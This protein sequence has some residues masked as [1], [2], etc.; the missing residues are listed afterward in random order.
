MANLWVCVRT[1]RLFKHTVW[2]NGCGVSAEVALLCP[3]KSW[4]LSLTPHTH[5]HTSGSTHSHT[6]TSITCLTHTNLHPKSPPISHTQTYRHISPHTAATPHTHRATRI[7][8]QY[9]VF[10]NPADKTPSLSIALRNRSYTTYGLISPTRPPLPQARALW[11]IHNDA[12]LL[13]YWLR[14]QNNHIHI[15]LHLTFKPSQHT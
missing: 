2:R 5:T 14:I 4:C 1:W 3:D 13:F 9:A 15:H 6:H 11:P 7:T 10:T 12:L 8:Q